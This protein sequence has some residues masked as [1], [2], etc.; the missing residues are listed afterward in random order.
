MT[1]DEM[2]I[3]LNK[4]YEKI[5]DGSGNHG[6]RTRC[7]WELHSLCRHLLDMVNVACERRTYFTPTQGRITWEWLEEQVDD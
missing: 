5:N 2:R 4:L 6:A 7:A 1:A 3:K